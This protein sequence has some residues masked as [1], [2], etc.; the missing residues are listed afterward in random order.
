MSKGTFSYGTANII[1]TDCHEKKNNKKTLKILFRVCYCSNQITGTKRNNYNAINTGVGKLPTCVPGFVSWNY[2]F[3]SRYFIPKIFCMIMYI[4]MYL[5]LLS[6]FT[7]AFIQFQ[8]LSLIQ[9]SDRLFF[10]CKQ[11][12]KGAGASDQ[13]YL[14]LYYGQCQCK[15]FWIHNPEFW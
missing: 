9:L 11:C 6:C 12:I 14:R 13:I 15:K 1:S 2:R 10:H 7:T 3:S 5:L 8:T 4:S